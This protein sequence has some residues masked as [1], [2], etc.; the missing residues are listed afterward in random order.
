VRD[1]EALELLEGLRDGF[2]NLGYQDEENLSELSNRGRMLI[3]RILHWQLSI[4]T[5]ELE[6]RRNRLVPSG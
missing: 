2:E 6:K 3:R 1:G 4:S 5:A